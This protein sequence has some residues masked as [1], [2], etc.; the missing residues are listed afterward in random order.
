MTTALHTTHPRTTRQLARRRRAIA[1]AAMMFLATLLATARPASAHAELLS[2]T[3]RADEVVPTS[4]Q[5]IVLIF[6]EVINVVD[7]SIRLVDGSG[8]DIPLND[9]GQANGSASATATVPALTNGSYVVAWH[10]VSADSHPISGAFTFSVGEASTTEPGLLGSLSSE[11][12]D[13]AGEVWLGIGRAGSFGG[14]ALLLGGALSLAVCAPDLGFTRRARR[15]LLIGGIVG[16]VGTAMMIVA[17]A[18]VTVGEASRWADVYDTRAGQWWFVRLGLLAVLVMAAAVLLRRATVPR[19]AGWAVGLVAGLGLL[20]VVTAGGHGVTGRHA[21][22]GFAA[23]VAH[24]AAM[25]T[26]VGGVAVMALVAPRDRLWRVAH[27]FSPMALASVAV[28]VGTGVTNAWRQS[29]SWDALVDSTYGRWL[30]VKVVVITFIVSVAAANRWLVQTEAAVAARSPS[31][32]VGAAVLDDIDGV[33]AGVDAS[34]L[35]DTGRVL[36]RTVLLEAGAML[37]VFATTAGLVNS[38]PARESTV[39]AET[40]PTTPATPTTLPAA[41][42]GTVIQ[43]DRTAVITVDPAVTGGTLLDVTLTNGV[44]P[45][46]VPTAITV[47]ASNL[48]LN[49]KA[50]DIPVI[51]VGDGHA[52]ATDADFPFAGTWT[53][54][55]SVRY[56]EFEQVNFATRIDVS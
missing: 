16:L 7:D 52:T 35:P 8:T 39:A 18:H 13:T 56:G 43:G 25:C 6:T 26:W 15:L 20:A 37:L 50:L 29:D 45:T 5:Q 21:G 32:A 31:A 54:L 3:P 27:R 55:V 38:P 28:L 12:P 44:T 10:V 53:I 19:V 24:L 47:S 22:L 34:E 36:R 9:I 23:T 40:T 1:L 49:I 42:S 33:G 46:E 41:V 48:L 4:P 11:P 17:Q 51:I 2:T 14:I 30:L